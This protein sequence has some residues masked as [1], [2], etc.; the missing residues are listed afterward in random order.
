MKKTPAPAARRQPAP[1]PSP[2]GL[3]ATRE[4]AGPDTAALRRFAAATGIDPATVR[5]PT[6]RRAPPAASLYAGLTTAQ[7]VAAREA[8]QNRQAE[9]RR[10]RSS[11][12]GLTL[13]TAWE[14]V[15][16]AV[17]GIPGDLY[18]ASGPLS[19]WELTVKRDRLR[20]LG[21]LLIAL[22]ILVT[23]VV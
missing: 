5:P 13:R 16:E 10:T 15:K 19:L 11:L 3:P 4:P 6:R 17:V 18:G 7:E 12:A 2:S 20:G 1:A 23:A 14:D 8:A 21:L 9:A 22:A